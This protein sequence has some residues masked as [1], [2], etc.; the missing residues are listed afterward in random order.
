[1]AFTDRFGGASAA[2]YQELNLALDSPDP[3]A[4]ENLRRVVAD[5]APR[6]V[7]A[8]AMRQVHGNDVAVVER[9]GARGGQVVQ[10]DGQ[11]SVVPE[12]VLVVRV[13]DCV[14]VLLADPDHGVVGVA[15]AGRRGMAAG[16]ASR[17]V[18]RMRQLGAENLTAWIGP[19][20]CGGCYEVPEQ[21]QRELVADLPESRATTTW[22]TPSLDLGAGVR[23]QLERAD[24]R[25]Q[26][27]GGCT[28]ESADLYSYRRDG[29]AAGRMAG[30]IRL[31]GHR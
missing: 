8:P 30:L 23:A 18:D 26:A 12:V 21:M 9:P 11:V 15:H 19:H 20:I 4:E 17:T 3:A 27:V 28:R 7:L 6:A 10:V 22:G 5:F 1:L 24:V 16:I 2:P 29:H 14:P 31:R 13:A 25:V